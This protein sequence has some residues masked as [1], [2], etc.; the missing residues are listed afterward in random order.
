MVFNNPVWIKV[1]LSMSNMFLILTY[2]LV[3][4]KLIF[5]Q[6]KLPTFTIINYS[7]CI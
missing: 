1:Y 5:T 2:N 3:I 7:N 6:S 4:E